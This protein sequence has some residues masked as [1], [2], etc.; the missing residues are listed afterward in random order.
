MIEPVVAP[1]RQKTG[2]PV[3]GTLYSLSTHNLEILNTVTNNDLQVKVARRVILTLSVN[4]NV[5]QNN[6]GKQYFFGTVLYA[7]F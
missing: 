6:L 7:I 1:D 3:C 2:L 4:S 5:G